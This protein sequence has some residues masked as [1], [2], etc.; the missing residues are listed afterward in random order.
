MKRSILNQIR[1][2]EQKI[3]RRLER[4]EGGMKPLRDGPEFTTQRAH[5]ELSG[6]TNAIGCGGIGVVHNL[7]H[8]SGLAKTI[9][10]KLD[11]LKRHRPYHE[12]DHVL[13][14]AYNIL[15]GGKTFEDI[16]RRRQDA[17]YHEALGARAIPDASTAGDFCRRFGED[18]IWTLMDAINQTRIG[19]WRQRGEELLGQTACIDADGSILETRGECLQ[20]MEMSYKGLWGYH[21][22]VVS[23]ANTNEPLYIVNRSGNR[24]SHEGAAAV[25]DKAIEVCREAGFESVRLRGDT[26]FSQTEHLDRWT[27]DG[28]RFVFG[29]KAYKPMVGRAEAIGDDEY[30]ELVRKTEE[31]LA[32]KKRR[33]KQPRVKEELVRAH[34]YKNLV[35]ESEE[36]AEFEYTPGK[37][38]KPYRMIVLKKNIR[39]EKGQLCLGMTVRYFFYITNDHSLSCAEVVAQSNQRCNQEN[40]IAQLGDGGVRSLHAPLKTLEANWAY[41]VIASLAWTL[42]AWFA[43][44]L[45]SSPRWRDKHDAQ[46]EGVLR[47]EFRTF[48][49]EFMLIPAQIIRSGRQLI[50]RFLAWRPQ[51][52]VLFRLLDAL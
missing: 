25:L 36:L 45:P 40:L 34:E 44:L 52:R 27:G 8:F 39:E 3:E 30:E 35:L 17:N 7:V 14:I 13:N 12:S 1:K 42:K 21:P 9:D 49:N 37:A 31:L 22:L 11:L 51:M 26:D 23:L 4:A 41:M 24:P 20:G 43:L 46:R 16:K 32:D 5:Y 2:S 10:E 18:D 38:S 47:M 29:Y 28:V 19:V 48:L 33:A 6:R 50:Y 15:C